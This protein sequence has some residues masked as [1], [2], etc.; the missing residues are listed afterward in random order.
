MAAVPGT[1]LDVRGLSTEFASH[2]GVLRAVDDVSFNLAP[3]EVLGI[4]GESGSGKSVTALSLMGLVARPGRIAAGSIRL[5]GH[6]DLRQKSAAEMR[7]LRGAVMSMIF[8]EP[9]TSLNP[10]FRVGWQIAEAVRKHLSLSRPEAQAHAVEMLDRVGIPSAASRA[11]DFP[12]Q[13]SGGM[14]QRVMIA[15]ALACRPDL[16]LADEPTTALDVTVQAQILDLMRNLQQEAGTAIVLITHDMGVIAETAKSVVVMYAGQVV[17][18]AE[19]GALFDEPLHPYTRGLLGSIPRGK[20]RGEALQAIPGV[21]PSLLNL[22]SGCRFRDRCPAA[23]AVCER[24]EPPFLRMK[25]GRRV[26]C[27]LY[28]TE[29]A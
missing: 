7:R 27:W 28:D 5:A 18:Q 12:H 4:V 9:M 29:A 1:L 17:E 16:L 3:G 11:R 23:K 8:Q 20:G 24:S 22:P 2:A 25:D 15:M 6:G 10:V 19:V 14:R 21:V 13:L 26:R